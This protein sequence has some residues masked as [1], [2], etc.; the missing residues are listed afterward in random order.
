M[1]YST[2]VRTPMALGITFPI[3]ATIAV[4]ARFHARRMKRMKWRIDDWMLVP[5]LFLSIGNAI[6]MLVA[7]THGNLGKLMPLGE[8]GFPVVNPEFETF[9]KCIY[10][11]EILTT[12][13]IAVTRHAIL[14]F[15]NRIFIGRSFN[16]S[17]WALYI[18]NG[19]WGIAYIFSFAFECRP[20]RAFWEATRGQEKRHCS[21]LI[22]IKI[23]AVASIV[24]DLSMLLIPW[25]PILRLKMRRR[26]KV[27][28]LGIF[29][30]GAL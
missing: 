20:V 24:I 4:L 16:L 1:G 28:V 22:Q 15:Y 27:A 3:I 10:A 12:A 5:A 26:E 6:S 21:P 17:V 8:D 29:G 23:Y 14:L 9:Q 25:P 13:A 19:I 18:L 30:L 11:N 2:P 7:A